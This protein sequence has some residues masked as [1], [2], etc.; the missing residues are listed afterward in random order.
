MAS[1][2]YIS[3]W[4]LVPVVPVVPVEQPGITAYTGWH[5]LVLELAPPGIRGDSSGHHLAL[6]GDTGH[7]LAL[8][9]RMRQGGEKWRHQL[10]IRS[11]FAH[12]YI[13]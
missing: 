9:G 13:G 12:C 8:V 2:G 6:L 10:D 1:S 7:H 5:H 11:Q 4:Y 3:T